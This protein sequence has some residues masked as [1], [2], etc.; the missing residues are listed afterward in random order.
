MAKKIQN[1][2]TEDSTDTEGFKEIMK[3]PIHFISC[4]SPCSVYHFFEGD[5][6]LKRFKRKSSI[7]KKCG[8]KKLSEGIYTHKKKQSSEEIYCDKKKQSS[9]EIYRDKKKQPTKDIFTITDKTFQPSKHDNVYTPTNKNSVPIETEDKT[10]NTIDA[11][12]QTTP[13]KFSISLPP[14]KHVTLPQSIIRPSIEKNIQPHGKV[15]QH[16]VDEKI[17]PC[18]K[19]GISCPLYPTEILTNQ[20]YKLR[21][22][23]SPQSSIT[24]KNSVYFQNVETSVQTD[25]QSKDLK[26]VQ[27]T[28]QRSTQTDFPVADTVKGRSKQASMQTELLLDDIKIA[29]PAKPV[30]TQ[31]DP[32]LS[33]AK[34][35]HSII[36]VE[37]Q[38]SVN[39]P[40]SN[41]PNIEETTKK[42]T[43]SNRKGLSAK[44]LEK[45]LKSGSSRHIK[46]EKAHKSPNKRKQK[47]FVKTPP[48]TRQQSAFSQET[49]L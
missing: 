49:S 45:K 37:S 28:E 38:S 44:S 35:R 46:H 7:C 23:D 18:A 5:T 42:T 32:T 3:R 27:T 47:L 1:C 22:R 12:V 36:T 29:Q 8:Y 26:L 48:P 31:T 16:C 43:H 10:T 40:K 15:T 17:C 9:E 34:A 39:V 30:S 19:N 6:N 21:H 25:L 13:E 33:D 24:K 2:K 41:T 4:L 14:I 11:E 20:N